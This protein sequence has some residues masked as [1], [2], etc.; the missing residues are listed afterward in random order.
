MEQLPKA[1][2][3]PGKKEITTESTEHTEK[4]SLLSCI[5]P[6]PPGESWRMFCF[7]VVIRIHVLRFFT[8]GINIFVN[9]VTDNSNNIC[10]TVV[11]LNEVSDTGKRPAG[12]AG[13]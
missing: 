5:L 8:A 7:F 11:K 9:D 2:R 10:G 12:R 1:A 6:P 3:A 4:K 13:Q